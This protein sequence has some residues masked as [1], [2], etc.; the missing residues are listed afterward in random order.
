MTPP[1]RNWSHILISWKPESLHVRLFFPSVTSEADLNDLNHHLLLPEEVR[2]R[3]LF[4]KPRKLV[5]R[6]I[7]IDFITA[8]NEM[9]FL[10]Y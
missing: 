8:E 9:G 3:A 4:M 10:T 5:G 7:N 2:Y 6:Q 1:F